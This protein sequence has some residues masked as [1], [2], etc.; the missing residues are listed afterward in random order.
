[1]DL[2]Y[3]WLDSTPE[4][5]DETAWHKIEEILK[6]RGWMSLNRMTSRILLVE[7]FEQV[8]LGFICFQLVPYV[9]PI[10]MHPSE[11]GNG[12]AEEMARQMWEFLVSVHARGW[13]AGAESSHG[14]KLCELFGMTK[15]EHPMYVVV[16][17]EERKT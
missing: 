5:N 3:R 15:I 14:A 17:M 2:K 7:D 4:F 9:G 13:L 10:W 12:I 6:F 8:L 11:R 1:M 16:G